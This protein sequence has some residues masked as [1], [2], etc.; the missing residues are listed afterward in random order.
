MLLMVK[1]TISTGPAIQQFFVCLPE[2]RSENSAVFGVYGDYCLDFF[3]QSQ[4]SNHSC[5]WDDEP[6]DGIWDMNVKK[7]SLFQ[8]RICSFINQ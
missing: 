8:T 6:G 2:G 3:G 5:S 4:G 7:K 1:S